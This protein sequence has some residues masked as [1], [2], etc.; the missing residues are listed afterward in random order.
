MAV[1]EVENL[2]KAYGATV[3]VAETDPGTL[4]RELAEEPCASSGA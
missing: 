2:R 1:I 3:P 4:A